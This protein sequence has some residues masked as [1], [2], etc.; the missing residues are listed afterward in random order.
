MWI[1]WRELI[2]VRKKTLRLPIEE[3]L[4]EKSRKNFPSNWLPRR[5]CC[6]DFYICMRRPPLVLNDL[7]NCRISI[8]LCVR[9]AWWFRKTVFLGNIIHNSLRRQSVAFHNSVRSHVR[10]SFTYNPAI[11]VT[12]FS[13]CEIQKGSNSRGRKL[14]KGKLKRKQF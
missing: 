13:C 11:W 8:C 7:H 14:K 1:S 2:E 6:A 5:L 4:H 3:N 10:F 9:V 12:F